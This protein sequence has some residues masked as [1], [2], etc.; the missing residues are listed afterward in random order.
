[1]SRET[2]RAQWRKRVLA[3][4]RSGLT[5][6]AWCA[7]EGVAKATLDYWRGRSRTVL[8]GCE[9]ALIPII[10]SDANSAEAIGTDAGVLEIDMGGG[11]RLRADAKVNA[12]WLACVLRGLR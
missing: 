11:V 5:R 4:E 2:K 9:T 10:V 12:Q 8:E 3:F 6:T 1:M 7:R